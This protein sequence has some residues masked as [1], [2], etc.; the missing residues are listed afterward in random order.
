MAK[1]GTYFILGALVAMVLPYI[2]LFFKAFEISENPMFPILSLLFGGAGVVLHLFAAL[3]TNALN[4]SSLILLTSILTIIFGFSLKTLG[5]PNA[6]YL[7]LIGTLLV[8]VWIMIPG[9]KKEE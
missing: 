2:L 3:K 9:T 4:S 5:I 7:L 1:W 8:A 6:Q